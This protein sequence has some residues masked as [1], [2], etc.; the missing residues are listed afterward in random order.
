MKLTETLGGRTLEQVVNGGAHNNPL[1]AGVDGEATD[2]HAVTAGDGL[3]RG[4]LSY[5]LHKS[6]AS[7]AV[8]VDVANI[9]R[10]Q[11]LLEGNADALLEVGQNAYQ[12]KYRG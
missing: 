12:K 1:A 2:L 7:V 10:G 3:D 8:L 11:F 5:D 4:G 6:L 9:A